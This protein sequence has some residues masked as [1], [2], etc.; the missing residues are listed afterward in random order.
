MALLSLRAYA[1][2]RG[3]SLAAV[4]KAIKSGRIATTA[5]GSIDSERANADWSA[6]TRPG[7]KRRSPAPAIVAPVVPFVEPPRSDPGGAGGLDYFRARAIRESY[8]A[9][10]AKIEFEEK[11][12]KLVS[13]DEVQVAAFTKARTVR[14]SLL[15][16][17][18]R[19]AA[20]LAAETDADNAHQMLTVEIRKA[21]DEL[22]GADRD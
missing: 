13:R 22:A 19:L 21:L 20:T 2:H 10:L 11:S 5:D 15:N 8:L 14:D 4:Q 1:K 9:R 18:D 3:V 7:Q 6:K 17:P 12:A 16:I